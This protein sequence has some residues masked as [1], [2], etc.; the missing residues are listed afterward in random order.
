MEASYFGAK[1]G[2][3][4]KKKHYSHEHID[5]NLL[6]CSYQLS[7]AVLVLLNELSAGEDSRLHS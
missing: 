5:A 2:K 7:G 6:F 4:K 1:Q 3:K